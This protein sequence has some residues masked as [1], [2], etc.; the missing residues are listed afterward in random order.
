MAAATKGSCRQ[1]MFNR[2][3]GMMMTMSM[4]MTSDTALHIHRLN[5]AFVVADDLIDALK[6]GNCICYTQSV[7]GKSTGDRQFISDVRDYVKNNPNCRKLKDGARVD[8]TYFRPSVIG[9]HATR[10]SGAVVLPSVAN[11]LAPSS[12]SRGRP[13]YLAWKSYCALMW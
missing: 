11:P 4:M 13:S 8:V 5:E 9:K 10:V 6:S 7:I 2:Q 12:M 3:P 1:Q